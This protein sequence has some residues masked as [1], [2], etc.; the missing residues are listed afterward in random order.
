VRHWIGGFAAAIGGKS[1]NLIASRRPGASVPSMAVLSFFDRPKITVAAVIPLY[2]G[3]EFIEEALLS[4]SDQTEAAD[5]I[6]VVDDGSTDDGPLIVERLA[7][8][9]N[10]TLLQK[11]NGGQSSARNMG[12]RH[13]N[14][15]HIAFLDQDDTWYD[16]HL[17]ILKQQFIRPKVRNLALVYGNLDFVDRRGQMVARCC[18]DQAGARHPKESLRQCLET[19]QFILPSASL[20]SRDAMVK[21]G[22]FDERL[23]G[24]EDDDLFLR[25]FL[26]GYGNVYLNVAVTRWRIYGGSTSFST[27]MAKS[28]MIYF[29]KQV[30]AFPDDTVL[31]LMWTR[32]VIAPRFMKLVFTEFIQAS[33][34]R[35]FTKVERAWSD[36]KEIV[37]KMHHR[38]RK[39]MKIYSPI[40]ERLNRRRMAGVARYLARRAIRA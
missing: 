31:D 35:D 14:C 18:L 11:K 6:I 34:Q 8:K 19:D 3:A 39:R 15:S 13:A 1:V 21:V 23:S 29:R 24:Y 20:V 7:K 38:T 36:I 37:P 25:M 10:I 22:L 17:H 9:H 32:D 16:N 30:E 40:I 33:R 12:V 5:E 4:V 2:N 26:A 28:R 27:R